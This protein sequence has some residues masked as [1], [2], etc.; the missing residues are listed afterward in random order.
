MCV[1]PHA[2]QSMSFTLT[3]RPPPQTWTTRPRQAPTR[4]SGPAAA[5]MPPGYPLV[6]M[7]TPVLQYQVAVPLAWWP[8]ELA[9]N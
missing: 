6:Q 8:V 5:Y 3:H 9:R 4:S 7:L 1:P 2:H